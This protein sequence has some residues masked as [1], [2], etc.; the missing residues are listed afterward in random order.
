MKKNVESIDGL[1]CIDLETLGISSTEGLSLRDA[2]C[3]E[4]VSTVVIEP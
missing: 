3:F 1:G 4:W 2:K